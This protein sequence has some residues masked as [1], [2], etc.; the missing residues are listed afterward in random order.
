LAG[1]SD[2]LAGSISTNDDG[3][4]EELEIARS[5][6]GNHLEDFPAQLLY[7][8]LQT[9]RL[10]CRASMEN[11]IKIAKYLASHPKI[12][13]VLTPLIDSHPGQD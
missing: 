10:R 1:H 13:R 2:T 3:L 5:R 11:G 4:F 9:L 6:M 7:E 12:E 8:G